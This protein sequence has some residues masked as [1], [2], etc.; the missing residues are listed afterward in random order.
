MRSLMSRIGLVGSALALAGCTAVDLPEIDTERQWQQAMSRISL[1][2]I[3]PPNEDVQV[4]DVYLYVPPSDANPLYPRFSVARIGPAL[5]GTLQSALCVQSIGRLRIAPWTTTAAL[6]DE[7]PRGQGAG[8]AAPAAGARVDGDCNP[9]TATAARFR[10]GS[11]LSDVEGP[12]LMRTAMPSLTVARLTEGQVSGMFPLQWVSAQFGLS[13]VRQI[14]LTV[15]LRGAEMLGIDP[16]RLQQYVQADLP[17]WVGEHLPPARLIR[18]VG[19]M[20]GRVAGRLCRGE[21]LGQGDGYMFIANQVLY[22]HNIQYEFSRQSTTSSRVL[23]DLSR[24]LPLGTGA[25]AAQSP[26]GSATPLVVVNNGPQRPA[27]AGANASAARQVAATLRQQLF[28]AQQALAGTSFNR[29]GVVAS[30]GIGTSGGLALN[31]QF[32][33]PIAVGLGAAVYID[34][35]AALLAFGT[36]VPMPNT[37]QGQAALRQ[38]IN[39]RIAEAVIACVPYVEG[40]SS[41]AGMQSPLPTIDATTGWFQ[42]TRQEDGSQ[43]VVLPEPLDR[44]RSRICQNML[45]QVLVQAVAELARTGS[46]GANAR[47]HARYFSG[48]ELIEACAAPLVPVSRASLLRERASLPRTAMTIR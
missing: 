41:S 26:T 7:K 30:L 32:E 46:G 12:R 25:G 45:R 48:P 22:S 37:P 2:G 24:A 27:D 17:K 28:D 47:A 33:R 39:A 5:P 40:E 20:N 3:Y 16:G 14:A 6:S 9:T 44:L 8:I 19:A 31:D 29:A 38:Q 11:S 13:S 15:N 34:I 43:R 23:A 42:P 21:M 18:T 4:G 1:Y 35:P 10:V 36:D